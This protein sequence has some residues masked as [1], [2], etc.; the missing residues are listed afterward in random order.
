[1]TKSRYTKAPTPPPELEAR[2]QKVLEVLSGTTTVSDAARQLG[3]SRNHFQSVLNTG[4]TGLLEALAPKPPGPKARSPE[5]AELLE[6]VR[7]LEEDNAFLEEKLSRV[8]KLMGLTSEL[9]RGQRGRG[10][11]AAST[12]PKEKATKSDSDDEPHGRARLALDAARRM[13]AAGAPAAWAACATGTSA[14]TLRRW[15]A[16]A[17]HGQRLC[18][19]RGPP[20]GSAMPANTAAAEEKVRALNG[21]IGAAALAHSGC[22]L[23]R[24]ESAVVIARVRTE[25]EVERK[26]A[27]TRIHVLAAG[28]VRGFDA[29]FALTMAGLRPVLVSADAAVPY[30]TQLVVA[31]HYDELAV[32]AALAADFEQN[33]APLVLRMDRA[34]QHATPRVSAVLDAHGVLVLHG[35]PHCP[36]YYG[37]LERQNREHQAWLLSLG[38]VSTDELVSQCGLMK[39]AFNDELPRRSLGWRTASEVWGERA[40]LKLDRL[41]F[42]EEV[43]QLRRKLDEE[44]QGQWP[45]GD[46]AQRFAIEATLKQH[47][48][49]RGEL[50]GGVR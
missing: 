20:P 37:Q 34:K 31:E 27:S 46:A 29:M 3:W 13:R 18:Q 39:S 36:R 48:L 23:S 5:V 16:R 40:A 25:L 30:R 14:A 10:R 35:P 26:A 49:L 21:C 41:V 1:M 45:Y 19:R 11:R 9:M 50:G 28:L 2:F 7:Q 47:G 38:L 17:A 22:G 43:E 33:G 24:R 6:R 32:A 8:D 42:R 12:P 44:N 15:S 4:L